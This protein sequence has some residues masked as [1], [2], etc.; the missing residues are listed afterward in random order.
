MAKQNKEA[1]GW[2]IEVLKI[3]DSIKDKSFKLQDMYAFEKIL[4]EKFPN[5]NFVKDKIRQQLQVI[6]DKGLI[7]FKGNGL[8]QKI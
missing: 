3:V 8:Y 5:N 6:R 1:R 2:T 7:K 4:K